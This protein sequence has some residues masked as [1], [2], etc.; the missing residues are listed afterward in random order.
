MCLVLRIQILN[1]IKI[2]IKTVTKTQIKTFYVK[3]WFWV[4]YRTDYTCEFCK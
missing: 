1:I 3:L 2:Y 4:F